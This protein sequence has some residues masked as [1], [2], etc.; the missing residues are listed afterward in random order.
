MY[1]H[2]FRPVVVLVALFAVAWLVGEWVGYSLPLG[3]GI[4]ATLVLALAVMALA[5]MTREEPT[6]PRP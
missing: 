4:V 5:Y 1:A 6:R 3:G 2:R